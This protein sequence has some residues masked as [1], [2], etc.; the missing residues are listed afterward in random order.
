MV[1]RLREGR[2]AGAC[3]KGNP[4][5]LSFKFSESGLALLYLRHLPKVVLEVC[6]S[7]AYMRCRCWWSWVFCIVGPHWPMED[8]HS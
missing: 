3:A 8:N 2:L 7:M 1:W 4:S 5:S 6:L